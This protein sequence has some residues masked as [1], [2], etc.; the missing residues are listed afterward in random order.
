M[1]IKWVQSHRLLTLYLLLIY[2][3]L[4]LSI[5]FYYTRLPYPSYV[6]GVISF[7]PNQFRYINGFSNMYFDSGAEDDDLRL[8]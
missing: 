2:K 4:L 6:G 5:F 7:T 3:Y 8:R 1:C